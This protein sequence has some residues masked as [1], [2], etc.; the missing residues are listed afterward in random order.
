[1]RA[2]S[3]ARILQAARALF[4]RRGYFQSRV[5]DIAVAADMSQG[6]IYWYFSS[7]EEI[8][9]AVLQ[10]GFEA[11]DAVLREAKAHPGSGAEKVAYAVERY[12]ALTQERADF[13]PILMSVLAHGG[14]PFLR[15]LGFDMAKIGEGYHR[16]LSTILTQARAEGTVRDVEPNAL[17]MFFFAFF[18][19]LIITY[20][21]DWTTLP[22]DLIQEAVL[23]LLGGQSS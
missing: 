19:G 14:E 11:V 3:R 18:N 20:G 10:D 13:F 1:M 23:G 22:P 15:E 8:L 21:D 16:H 9:K 17:A 4:S 7:K 2:E 5:S 12:M 6:N